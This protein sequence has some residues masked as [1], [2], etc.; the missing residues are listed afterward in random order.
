M[1]ADNE[2]VA[3]V[4]ASGART[5]REVADGDRCLQA[6]VAHRPSK[7]LDGGMLRL[8]MSRADINGIDGQKLDALFRR[9]AVASHGSVLRLMPR[10]GAA[11]RRT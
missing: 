6:N 2:H 8:S 1:R 7:P 9:T 11:R 10:F 3:V 5:V 4:C